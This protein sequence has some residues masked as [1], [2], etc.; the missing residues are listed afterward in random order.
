ML[1]YVTVTI[2]IPE[3]RQ[4]DVWWNIAKYGYNFTYD[5]DHVT[6]YGRR[7][8]QDDLDFLKQ[9]LKDYPDHTLSIEENDL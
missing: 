9:R 3:E 6:L 5:Q 2:P 7:K 8:T 4:L 1:Y